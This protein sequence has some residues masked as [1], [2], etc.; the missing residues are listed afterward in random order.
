M[1]EKIVGFAEN[2]I[3]IALIGAGGIGKTSVA[4]TVLHNHHIKQRFGDNRWFIRCDQL[5]A[6]HSHFLRR[7]SEVIG[8]GIENPESLTPLRPFLSSKEML[9]VL[10]NAESIL[11]PQ[12]TDAQD[13]YAAVEELSRFSN[14]CVCITSRISTVPPDCETI[15]VPTLSMEAARDTFYRIYKHD[16]GSDSVKNL[17][18]QLDFHPLSITLLATVAQHNKWDTNRLTNEWEPHRTGVLHIRHNKSLA[19]TVE[20]SLASPLFQELGPDARALLGVVAFFP[21]GV[22]ESNVNWL[23]PAISNGRDILDQF[24]VLSDIPEQRVCH[25]ARAAP[26]LS[27]A[28]G[29]SV[30]PTPLCSQG[31]LLRPDDSRYRS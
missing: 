25:D 17:L 12:G 7:L 26:R 6:S 10:D 30:V 15:D 2:L 23:F 29:S 22:D 31:A 1:V 19:A 27:L 28:R 14:L 8:A 4:L 21:Q 16:E 20:L 18:K 13:I 24:C 11:D 3:P 9:I 5:P